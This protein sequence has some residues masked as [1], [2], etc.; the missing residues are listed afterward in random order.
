MVD[1]PFV[2]NTMHERRC[3]I[4]MILM[5]FKEETHYANPDQD[6][7]GTGWSGDYEIPSW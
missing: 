7:E 4:D 5:T 1:I 3:G 6:R 2:I